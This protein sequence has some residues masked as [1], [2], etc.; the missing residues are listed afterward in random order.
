MKGL[1]LLLTMALLTMSISAVES[2]PPG[3]NHVVSFVQDDGFAL[4]AIV[5]EDVTFD[6]EIMTRTF[7]HS[8]SKV[9]LD[10]CFLLG[11]MSPFI[12]NTINESNT[13]YSE[14]KENVATNYNLKL[15]SS[16]TPIA[17][18]ANA[19]YCRRC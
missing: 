14:I 10:D 9:V 16:Y 2:S 13:F 8:T 11:C 5:F 18:I 12:G 19:R 6:T 4:Q 1:F 15:P 3:V 7:Y 17:N